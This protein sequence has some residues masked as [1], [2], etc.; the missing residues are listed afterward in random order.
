MRIRRRTKLALVSL[1]L[2]LAAAAPQV[3]PQAGTPGLA[4]LPPDLETEVVRVM[5][6]FDVPGLALAIVK[7]D[8]VLL[9]KGYG[10][11][12][13]GEMSL[14]D[15][16]TLFG[17]A[18]NT[19]VFTAA[20]LGLL[21]EEGKVAWDVPVV[22]YLPWFQMWDPYVTREIT[23]R[24]L[25]VHRSGLGLGA[26]DLLWWPPSTYGRK[27]IVRR[28]RFIRPASSFR[29]TYAYDNVLYLAAGELIEAVSG[30]SWESFVAERILK[31]AGMTMSRVNYSA[32]ANGGNVAGTHALV[33]GTLRSV[34]AMDTENIAPAGGINSSALDMARWM[35][36]LLNG[37]RLTGGARLMSERTVREL[38]TLVTPI[39]IPKAEPELAALEPHFRGY[40]LGLGLQDYRG[41][42]VVAHTGGLPGYLSKVTLLP[43]LKLGVAVLTN[44][45][46]AD[47]FNALSWH[48]VDY[49]LGAPA[50]DWVEAFR[51]VRKRTESKV[52]EGLARAEAERH[53][54]SGPSLAPG[55]YAGRYADAWYGDIR[56]ALEDGR[57]V[58]R[59][60]HTPDLVGDLEHWQYD[61]FL[62]RWRLR[63]LRADALLTF[64]LNP[65]G[66]I[67]EARMRAVSPETDFS[68]DFQDLRL[69]PVRSPRS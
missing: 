3:R 68:F 1:I 2:G 6:T 29:S 32:T 26:G 7:D 48:V 8:R 36:V 56:I 49:Y 10:L 67:A 5:K 65:D 11:R 31:P 40:G 43:E 33:E 16:R 30:R 52:A 17:I 57:L 55:G 62:V 58:M 9:A 59:F 41:R 61:T 28:L 46:S 60:A 19:K 23:V 27:E 15:A 54:D 53:P 37:G 21:V 18:S 69:E 64:S 34:K 4:L 66:S 39:P 12:R 14:V 47:A 25:L 38:M 44:Q 63:E 50:T 35:L 24:D 13:L 42:E 22:D 45:E 51:T 20:A